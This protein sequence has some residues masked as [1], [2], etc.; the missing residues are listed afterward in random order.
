MAFIAG[1]DT[2]SFL[3]LSAEIVEEILFFIATEGTEESI[4][5]PLI[6]AK[7]AEEKS[8]AFCFLKETQMGQGTA[9]RT[10]TFEPGFGI[11]FIE[12]LFR[13]CFNRRPDAALN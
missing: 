8:L 2:V 4:D 13:S 6:P 11:E 9:D 3:S 7:R 1:V 10:V 12:E 5:S